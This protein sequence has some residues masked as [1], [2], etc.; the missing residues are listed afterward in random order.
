MRLERVTIYETC[1]PRSWMAKTEQNKT[2]HKKDNENLN[3]FRW[4]IMDELDSGCVFIFK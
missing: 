1:L 2:F 4:R 3:Q